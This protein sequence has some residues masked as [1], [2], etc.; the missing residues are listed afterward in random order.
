[1]CFVEIIHLFFLLIF[2]NLFAYLSN[3]DDVGVC[4]YFL[5]VAFS[6]VICFFFYFFVRNIVFIKRNKIIFPRSKIINKYY[7]GCILC[8]VCLFYVI[9]FCISLPI[10]KSWVVCCCC[11]YF[12]VVA[13][14][15]KSL[16]TKVLFS[17]FFCL[18]FTLLKWF[19]L[20]LNKLPSFVLFV[21]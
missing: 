13:F 6:G 8:L 4:C 19:F 11:C 2:I 20:I 9:F 5:L 7:W 10:N 21:M 14:A 12:V 15:Y 1:M 18:C 17:C 16:S 3:N